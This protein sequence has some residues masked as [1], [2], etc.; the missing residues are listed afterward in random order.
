MNRCHTLAVVVFDAEVVVEELSDSTNGAGNAEVNPDSRCSG[1]DDALA[2]E[3]RFF[4]DFAPRLLF[5]FAIFDVL[6]HIRNWLR[7][8]RR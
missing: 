6:G 8:P 5:G 4:A 7:C 3:A 1:R 2:L